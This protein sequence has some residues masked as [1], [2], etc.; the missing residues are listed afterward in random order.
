MNASVEMASNFLDGGLVVY[1]KGRHPDSMNTY[2]AEPEN[3]YRAYPW[4]FW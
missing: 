2:N 4:W 1:T 3:C